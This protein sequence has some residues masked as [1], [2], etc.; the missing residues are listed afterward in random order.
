MKTLIIETA[1]EKGLI[2]LAKE[3]RP[4][5]YRALEGGALL[6]KT[7]ASEVDRLLKEHS[8]CP[9]SI[10]VGKGPGSYTGV[11]VGMALAKTLSFGWGVPLFGFCS[12][13][14]FIPD[15]RR[16]P[17][18]FDA[19]M[20]GVYLLHQDKVSLVSPDQA[21]AL[22]AQEEWL[23]SPHPTSIQRRAPFSASWI[24]TAPSPWELARIAHSPETKRDN[25][26]LEPDYSR[27][28]ESVKAAEKP[29]HSGQQEA[30]ELIYIN[31]SRQ[32]T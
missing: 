8:F 2:V 4:L 7:L 32:K 31:P 24:E 29:T 17:V 3:E 21:H 28:L 12:L 16:C 11:R 26:P 18:L 5:A 20:G 22:L 9:D 27:R 14:A 10:A 30:T 25:R 1:T 13:A 19:R 15:E 6:S 23:A